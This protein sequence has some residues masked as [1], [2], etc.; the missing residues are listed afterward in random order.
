MALLVFC[1]APTNVVFANSAEGAALSMEGSTAKAGELVT[2]DVVISGNPGIIGMTL[3]VNYDSRLVLT[4][5]TNGDAFQKLEMTKP[6]EL[7]PGCRIHWDTADLSEKDIKD[8]NVVTLT[9]E[10]SKDA[11]AGDSCIVDV[12]PVVEDG[13]VDVYNRDLDTVVLQQANCNITIVSDGVTHTTHTYGEWKTTKQP[14]C[15]LPGTRERTCSI[16]GTT[17]TESINALGHAWG[18]GKVTVPPTYD[19][20]GVQTFTCQRCGNIRSEAIAKLAKNSLEGAIVELPVSER[21]SGRPLTPAPTVKLADRTLTKDID[22]TV[23]YFD[24]VNVGTATVTVTGT[25]NYTGAAKGTFKIEEAAMSGNEQPRGNGSSQS[26]DDEEQPR[27]NDDNGSDTGNGESSQQATQPMHRLY[28]PNSGEHFY[29]ANDS[30][31]AG[32]AEIGW[33][34]EGFGWNAPESSDTPVY[35]M[36]NPVAGEHH[37]TPDASERDS[38]LAAGWNDEG[39]GWYSDDARTVPLFRDYN[40]NAFANNHNYT[41]NVEEHATLAAAG[42]VD[43][44]IAWYGV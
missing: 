11:I 9:F 37:Y 44:G 8:G 25:G 29:T 31:A 28:N 3:E 20:E 12:G 5:V 27:G 39:V 22:Y 35:R 34:D 18:S 15:T 1:G 2:L 30:E 6:G 33:S 23:S 4:S 13:Q 32:L 14:T 16:C 43:E 41:A 40:P 21:Y 19:A 36:Y 26:G 38:L 10:I 24:N 17:T 42:W 7:K